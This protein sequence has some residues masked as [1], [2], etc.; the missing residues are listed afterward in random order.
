MSN[1]HCAVKVRMEFSNSFAARKFLVCV[2]KQQ[3][4]VFQLAAAEWNF[5]SSSFD[6]LFGV[7]RSWCLLWQIN[8]VTMLELSSFLVYLS[9]WSTRE[10]FFPSS[11]PSLIG[12]NISK[13]SQKSSF[14][15][16][17]PALENLFA[18]KNCCNSKVARNN[19]D[20]ERWSFFITTLSSG[21]RGSRERNVYC[22]LSKNFHHDSTWRVADALRFSW[23]S[24]S[25]KTFR[26]DVFRRRRLPHEWEE[27]VRKFSS[28]VRRLVEN[29]CSDAFGWRE[30]LIKRISLIKCLWCDAS[31]YL[32]G[33]RRLLWNFWNT[34]GLEKLQR[35]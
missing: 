1:L 23:N 17:S 11:C 18:H 16:Q 5:L 13:F 3:G 20:G 24:F 27:R 21:F 32:D 35:N 28:Y 10:S 31:F 7:L 33:R 2:G 9:K 15:Q 6:M 26:R 14:F 12:V 29:F 19:D 25:I 4:K 8:C 34:I 30:D 22:I